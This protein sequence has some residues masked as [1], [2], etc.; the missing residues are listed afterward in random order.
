M[1]ELD[2]GKDITLRMSI[3]GTEIK[4]EGRSGLLNWVVNNPEDTLTGWETSIWNGITTLELAKQID[5]YI[6]YPNI[7]GIYHL[8]PEHIISK[9]HLV[10]YIND[11][12]NCNKEIIPVPGKTENK[13]L[14]NTR[15]DYKVFSLIPDYRTQLLELKDFSEK[16]LT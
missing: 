11:V 16:I 2:N 12:F 8:V 3:V 10:S 4:K 7:S 5:S 6:K 15:N 13:T 9:Y 1:G 14:I